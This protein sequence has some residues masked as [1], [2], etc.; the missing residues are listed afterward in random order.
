MRRVNRMFPGVALAQEN[1]SSS[2]V[3]LTCE[4]LAVCADVAAIESRGGIDDLLLPTD[5]LMHAR[6][7]TR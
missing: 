7:A 5:K 4:N 6:Y 3:V 1:S 2:I